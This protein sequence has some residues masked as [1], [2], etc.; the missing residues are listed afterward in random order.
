MGEKYV[1]GGGT[2]DKKW[3][4]AHGAL[5]G[6]LVILLA[7]GVFWNMA[8]AQT[9]EESEFSELLLRLEAALSANDWTSAGSKAERASEL[10]KSVRKRLRPFM[11][12]EVLQ[13]IDDDL[14]RLYGFINQRHPAL[15][16]GQFQALKARWKSLQQ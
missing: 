14:A 5:V 10:W 3:T 9:G 8:K 7:I 16:H 6:A 11:S 1:N 15:A 4:M 2:L 12:H 13:D